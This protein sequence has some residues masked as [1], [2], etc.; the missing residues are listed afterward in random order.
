M[1][2]NQPL[3]LKFSF[4]WLQTY[5]QG[6][7]VYDKWVFDSIYVVHILKYLGFDKKCVLK[8]A[9]RSKLI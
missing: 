4:Q 7:S 3:K 1:S 5:S 6:T 9:K 2:C 8:M